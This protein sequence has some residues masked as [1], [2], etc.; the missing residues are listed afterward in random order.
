MAQNWRDSTKKIWQLSE[1][2]CLWTAPPDDLALPRDE[3]HVWRSFLHMPPP[4]IQRLRRHL[5]A[6]EQLKASRFRFQRHRIRYI[7]AHGA[8][9]VI[10][11]RYLGLE[12]SEL[13]FS[14]GSRG[15]PALP[16]TATGQTV[17]FN[18]SQS[19]ELAVCAVTWNRPIGI[20]LERI[21]TGADSE[22]LAKRFFSPRE[23][24]AI[25]SLP[26]KRRETAFVRLWTIK[27]AYLKATGEGLS[28]LEKIEVSLT[29]GRSAS[30][31]TMKDSSQQAT[32]SWSVHLLT[33][34]KG[35][36]GS[37]V[38]HGH[39]IPSSCFRT[40]DVSDLLRQLPAQP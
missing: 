36:L 16:P 14:S 10:L 4:Q 23:Y 29:P 9:R 37:I 7:V 17:C 15:K 35:Y 13:V 11:G 31:L 30:L 8:L 25:R 21:P 38:V 18:L 3:I 24:T 22:E 12:P 34:A 5:S 33:P 19:H 6:D 1:L 40:M 2:K 20:D 27:E 28:G 32:H 26:R 39:A